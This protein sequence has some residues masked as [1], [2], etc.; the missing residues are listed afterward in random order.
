M[1]SKTESSNMFTQLTVPTVPSSKFLYNSTSVSLVWLELPHYPKHHFNI[2]ALSSPKKACQRD[3]IKI[4]FPPNAPSAELHHQNGLN[5]QTT[6]LTSEIRVRKQSFPFMSH[7]LAWS[8]P[9]SP[10]FHFFINHPHMQKTC[11]AEVN[12]SSFGH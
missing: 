2:T 3:L 6:S 4:D 9:P 12:C 10:V 7:P 5:Q 11:L 8:L 1:G